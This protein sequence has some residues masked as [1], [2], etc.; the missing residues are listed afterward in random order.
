MSDLIDQ[1]LDLSRLQMGRPL[2]LHPQRVDLV[3]L[4]REIAAAS[5]QMTEQ[6]AV[7]VD[8]SV[9]ELVGVWDA[10]RLERAVQNLVSNAIKFSPWEAM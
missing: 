7:T 6:H 2:E 8:C 3:A 1:V 4:V 5:D 9:P 10:A